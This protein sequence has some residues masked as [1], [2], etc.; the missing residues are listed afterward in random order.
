M[1][2]HD[3]SYPQRRR[4]SFDPLDWVVRN[5]VRTFYLAWLVVG[6]VISIPIGIAG[7][8]FAPDL[9]RLMGVSAEAVGRQAVRDALFVP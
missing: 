4:E 5:P 1:S 7:G 3:P 6:V 2:P 8:V 9:L